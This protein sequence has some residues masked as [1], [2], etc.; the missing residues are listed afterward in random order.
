MEVRIGGQPV[1]LERRQQKQKQIMEGS[2]QA[3]RRF[4][5]LGFRVLGEGSGFTA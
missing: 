5:G 4:S 2:G 1:S 3:M